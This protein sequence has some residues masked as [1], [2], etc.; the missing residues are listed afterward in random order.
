M[1]ALLIIFAAMAIK[2]VFAAFWA[3]ALTDRHPWRAGFADG[4][5]DI[6]A[7]GFVGV[8]IYDHPHRTVT[9]TLLAFVA[10]FI[11]SVLGTRLGAWVEDHLHGRKPR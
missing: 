6:L 1:T 4:L 11:G 10:L 7:L 3:K 2:D 9:W 5:S 8:S